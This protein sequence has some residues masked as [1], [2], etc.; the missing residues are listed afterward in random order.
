MSLK[1][2]REALKE[3]KLVVGTSET[4]KALKKGNV[5]EVFVAKN[6]SDLVK[7]ELKALAEISKVTYTELDIANEELGATC[8]KPFSINCC[9][10]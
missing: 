8:K 2:L 9:Y 10:Y 6:C 4:I 7:S 3:K 5:K 1:S